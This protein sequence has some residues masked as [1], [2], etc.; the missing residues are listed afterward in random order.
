MIA[1]TATRAAVPGR[2]RSTTR[3]AAWSSAGAVVLLSVAGLLL[4]LANGSTELTDWWY[5]NLALASTTVVPGL[6][7]ADRRPGNPVGWLLLVSATAQAVCGT[8]R[9]YLIAGL[10]GMSLPGWLWVG[11]L[12]NPC[13]LISIACLLLLL[14]V[15]PDGRAPAGVA[16]WLL[17]LPVLGGAAEVLGE[18]L[19]AGTVWIGD[20]ELV[21]PAAGLTPPAVADTIGKAGQIISAAALLATV[22]VLAYRLR[23]TEG[24]GRE[25]L[26]WVAWAGS[27]NLIE[28]V[29]EFLPINPV[30]VYTS[31][32]TDVLLVA[33]I[34]VAILRH[35]L[36]DIDIVINRTLVYA[37]LTLLVVGGYLGVVALIDLL[38]GR[39]VLWGVGLVAAAVVAALFA[40]A[41]ARVQRGVDRLLYGERDSPYQVVTRLGRRLVEDEGPGEL[42][43]VVQTVAGALKLPYAAITD[44]AGLLV[45][46]YGAR[47]GATLDQ[48]L[49]YHGAEVGTLVVQPRSG[50]HGF[51]RSDRELLRDLARQVGAAVHAVRLSA[52]LQASRGRLVAAKEDERRRL[53]RDLHDGLGPRLAALGL[54][55]D[56]A[57]GLISRRPEAA[58]ELLGTV[59]AEIRG[60]IDQVRELVY[61]L[62]P[63][64]LDELGL[65]GALREEMSR[66]GSSPQ[67]PTV[68]VD[69]G[70]LPALPAAVEVAAY[71]I[72]TEAV[73]NAV[74]HAGGR[75]CRVRVTADPQVLRVSVS[76]DG[77]GLAGGWRPG[78]GTSSMSER[79]AE[80]GGRLS[81]TSDSAGTLV[82]AELP[83]GGAA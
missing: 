76:D 51:G 37:A 31:M 5:G 50:T 71:W 62:R 68:T 81:V 63:P 36:L 73:T 77:H 4:H 48:R 78:I 9:E 24:T 11:W 54:K 80:V 49:S 16:R 6:L 25:Q 70:P 21:S 10:R 47:T 29:T 58:G 74:R 39:P 38:L 34:G 72:A 13:Y 35:R 79:A 32:L 1:M 52:D 2:A 20:R 19:S 69:S 66:F 45:A 15:F 75:S 46:Q 42:E 82:L 53:R 60:T 61:G 23:H 7:I 43:V 3:F 44:P 65:A 41:R 17:A 64:S 33:A 83:L 56:A 12:A 27:I 14:M 55:V 40:P 67:G 22:G 30:A 28:L 26:K 18:L 8:G 59:A 57:Q